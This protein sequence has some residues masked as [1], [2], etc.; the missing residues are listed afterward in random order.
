VCYWE[1]V[2]SASRG[3]CSQDGGRRQE[4]EVRRESVHHENKRTQSQ[5]YHEERR[6]GETSISRRRRNTWRRIGRSWRANSTHRLAG[7]RK[8]D[9]HNRQCDTNHALHEDPIE[10]RGRVKAPASNE[11]RTT[12]AGPV[13]NWNQLWWSAA[14]RRKSPRRA[15]HWCGSLRGSAVHADGSTILQPRDCQGW[16]FKWVCCSDDFSKGPRDPYQ[17]CFRNQPRTQICLF[18]CSLSGK[19]CSAPHGHYRAPHAMVRVSL[20]EH[21]CQHR[22]S[23]SLDPAVRSVDLAHVV[24]VT[25]VIDCMHGRAHSRTQH[26]PT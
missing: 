13:A 19:H 2:A 8:S 5:P 20:L 21:A 10:E 1:R 3:S 26:P 15:E 22:F 9:K 7:A 12:E 17:I 25:S 11:P 14:L 18:V 23:P 24:G 16:C 6:S 4:D